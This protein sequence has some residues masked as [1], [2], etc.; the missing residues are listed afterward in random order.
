MAAVAHWLDIAGE[1]KDSL[2]IGNGASIAVHP[3]FGYSSLFASATEH[4]HI[5]ES[6]ARIFKQFGTEDFELV[7]RQLWQAMLVNRALEISDGKVEAAYQQVRTALIATIRV[8]HVTYDDARPHLEPIYRF[9]QQF[10]T[11][12]SL[13]YDLILYW[14]TRSSEDAIG[15]WFKDCFVRGA[16]N[17]DNWQDMREPYGRAAGATLFFYPHGN[18]VLTRTLDGG[19]SKVSAGFNNLL[20]SILTQWED[21]SVVPLFVCE[22][23]ADHKKRSIESSPYLHRVFREVMPEMGES[24]VVYGW[25][26]A[27]QDRHLLDQIKKRPPQRVA[28]SVYGDNATFMREAEEK[29]QGAGV[30][31]IIFFDATS[32]GCWNHPAVPPA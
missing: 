14:A 23:T 9:L 30:G 22:G 7:L 24:L 11:I 10:K 25:G 1:F 19:E 15:K 28:V 21:E 31:R 20:E 12:F 13:N 29:L 32:P 17:D 27:E 8:T 16:F 18:L 6:V 2:I 26:L 5:T 4:G 3:G